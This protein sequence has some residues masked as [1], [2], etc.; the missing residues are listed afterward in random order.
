M[1]L[2]QQLLIIDEFKQ[3][4]PRTLTR[5]ALN[6]Y[7]GTRRS[8][9]KPPKGFTVDDLVNLLLENEAMRIAEITSPRYGNKIR[10]VIGAVSPLQLAC[11]FYKDSY[12]SHGTALHLHGLAPLDTIF[13]NHEQSPKNST[14]R[15]TQAGLNKAFENHQRQS[16]YIFHYGTSMITFLNGKN[17][18]GAGIVEM[19]GPGGEPLKTT[20][21]ERTLIDTVVRPHYAGGVSNVLSACKQANDRVSVAEIGRLLTKVNYVYP[22]HQALG[23]I[24][25]QA[26]VPEK[27]LL[28]LKQR[29]IRFK[30]YLDY[31]MTQPAYDPA[32]KV[33]YPHDLLPT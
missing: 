27:D 22:Y 6:E 21:L 15:L 32:W 11:S 8:V 18:G 1:K 33:Y 31:G 24:L 9:W 10:Y 4:K 26:G 5:K 23:F 3:L 12:L 28:P 7:L 13:V 25:Q 16:T 19:Q 17:T 2:Q 30:F 14:S 29:T 20:S